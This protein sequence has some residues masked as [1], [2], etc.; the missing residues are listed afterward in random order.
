MTFPSSAFA[1]LIDK[2]EDKSCNREEALLNVLS[3]S[4]SKMREDPPVDVSRVKYLVQ[5]YG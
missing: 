2:I 4:T 5:G 1:T 3:L